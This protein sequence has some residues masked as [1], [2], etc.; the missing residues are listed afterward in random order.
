M[1]NP[2]SLP[3]KRAKAVRILT[4]CTVFSLVAAL[5]CSLWYTFTK[6]YSA[7]VD[8][9]KV[10]LMQ[11]EPPK[12]GDTIAIMHTTCGDLSYLLYPDCCPKA[13]ENFVQLAENG[14]YNGTYVFR[15]EKGIFFAGGSPNPDGSL[16]DD[17]PDDAP[18]ESIPR[19]LS[20]SL[21]PF[22]G[23]L[24]ALTTKQDGGFFRTLAGKQTYY[25]GSRFM[26]ANSVE[27]T[28]EMVEGLQ[29]QGE[30][31]I[32]AQAFIE[33]GGIPNYA[34]QITVFGQL[35]DGFDILD[36][37]T[38]VP[39]AGEADALHPAEDILIESIEIKAYAEDSDSADA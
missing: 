33:H 36:A 8:L 32:V 35:Y 4:I 3:P 16:L 19:E 5:G 15:V 22:R 21:W 29:S 38:N 28:D 11:L 2:R 13:V 23:A 10:E 7:T 26:V 24:C 20:Y 18:Q 34:Q 30:D 6:S 31:N 12:D 39:L 1:R 9:T 27:M 37:V 14:Y 25:N 17:V